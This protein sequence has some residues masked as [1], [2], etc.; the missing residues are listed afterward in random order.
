MFIRLMIYAGRMAVALSAAAVPAE[1][2]AQGLMGPGYP[3]P[4]ETFRFYYM[5]RM[6]EVRFL[7]GTAAP[8]SF[9]AGR[10]AGTGMTISA[11]VLRHPVSSKA[12]KLI[13]KAETLGENGDHDAAVQVLL[14]T[15]QRYPSAAP[16]VHSLLGIEYARQR[17]FLMAADELEH[18]VVLMPH[19][20]VDHSN[21]AYVLFQL[22]RLERAEAVVRRALELDRHFAPAKKILS[23]LQQ[24]KTDSVVAR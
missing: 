22:G 1:I 17:K 9:H 8:T 7:S 5:S 24:R 20:P 15:R 16:Y 4:G 2:C 14:D 12:V 3:D 23:L 6:P 10:P 19:D 18:A 11:D 21:L 13:Q